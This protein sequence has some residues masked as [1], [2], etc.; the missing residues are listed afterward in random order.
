MTDKQEVALRQQGGVQTRNQTAE[1]AL[2]PAA[3]IFETAEGITLQIDMPGVSKDRLQVH[4]D[5]NSLT[6]E[7]NAQFDMPAGME[8]LYAD[9]RSTLYRRSFA[10]SS[11]LDA[12]KI[13]AKLQDGVLTLRVPK[14]AEL[15]PRKIEVRAG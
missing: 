8:A 9:L 12:E 6:I 1:F 10:L 2:Q 3:D 14:R 4:S 5:R 13:D 11:E 15:R 7:G